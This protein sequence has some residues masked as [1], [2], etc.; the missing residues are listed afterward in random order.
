[1]SE[2]RT[3]DVS[4][5]G[6]GRSVEV[7]KVLPGDRLSVAGWLTPLPDVGDFLI[8][9]NGWDTTRYQIDTLDPCSNPADMFF[10]ELSFAPRAA[11][12]KGC[13]Q[14]DTPESKV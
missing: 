2:P 5:R 8:L 9:A 13:A 7:M 3:I 12:P 10:A 14:P 11:V 4:R 6:W 1:M